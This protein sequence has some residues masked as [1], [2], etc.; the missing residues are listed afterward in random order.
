MQPTSVTSRNTTANPCPTRHGITT[1]TAKPR[2]E[3]ET[4]S[5]SRLVL[6]VA[7]S[8]GGR[9]DLAA[10]ARRVA[11]MVQQGRLRPEEVRR[12]GLSCMGRSGFARAAIA[13][14]A[15]FMHA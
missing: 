9:Q 8:Y 13:P 4:A 11:E 1:P 2:A 15:A 10:A 12:C 3:A 7:L 5:N 6:C 14:T